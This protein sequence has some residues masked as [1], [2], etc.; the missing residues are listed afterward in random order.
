MGNYR[1]DDSVVVARVQEGSNPLCSARGL[2]AC[3]FVLFRFVS[4]FS[5][6]AIERVPRA[7]ER[8]TK[9]YE[10]VTNG[11]DEGEAKQIKVTQR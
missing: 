2:F 1:K 11:A 3:C 6:F 5:C 8:G 10:T 9:G 4:R 7:E